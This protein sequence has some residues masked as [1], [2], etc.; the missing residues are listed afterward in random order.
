MTCDNVFNGLNEENQKEDS[1]LQIQWFANTVALTSLL[2]LTESRRMI[3]IYHFTFAAVEYACWLD[4]IVLTPH[5]LFQL[6]IPKN[7]APCNL[8][9]NMGVLTPACSKTFWP[10]GQY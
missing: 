8:P 1:V 4:L 10:Q 9:L 5:V 6:A 2:G 3:K 7:T